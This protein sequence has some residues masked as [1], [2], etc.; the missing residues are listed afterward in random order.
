[1]QYKLFCRLFQLLLFFMF[2]AG[3]KNV[4]SALTDRSQQKVA[5][6]NVFAIKNMNV[7]PMT[8]GAEILPN[9]T[10]IIKNEKIVSLSGPIPDHAEIIDGKG[11]WLLPGLI[12]MHVHVPS[13]GHFNTTFPTRAAT[14]FTNTQDVMTPYVANGVTTIFEL[15]AKAGHF[16]QRNE[17]ARGDVIG[18]RM[19]LAALIN[20]GDG[21]GRIANTPSDGRQTVRIAKAEGYEFIKVY[22]QLNIETYKAIVDEANKQGLKV[23][24]HIPN[25]FRGKLKDAFVPHFGMVAHAEE[26]SKQTEAFSDQD[27][28]RFAQLAKE[29]GTWITPTLTIMV[30]AAS[31]ARSLDE[32]R[33]LHSLQY[34]HPLLQSKWLTSNNYN[35][36]T[37]PNRVAYFEKMINFHIRLVRA[38]KEAG[39][40]MVVGTDAGS[41][42]VVGGFSLHDE[43]ELLVEAGLTPEEA[44]TSATRLPS[45]W[46]GIDSK[47]GTVEAGK[48]ADLVLLD[49]NPLNDI[50]NTRKIS[51]VFV[52]G[53]WLDKARI[54]AMLSDLS[55]RNTASK[56][57]YDWKKR[58]EY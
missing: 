48:Y 26:F 4:S 35:K 5:Q 49:A 43:I 42:G 29:N 10:V 8:S 19:A 36:G 22:S 51:G 1:M 46:L 55:K 14:I 20:G 56:D 28:K 16:G 13:D 47:V 37:S 44:L 45:I 23:I 24:G 2:A 39:V 32:L 18:P 58:E 31:Q 52:N 33:A 50:K 3:C 15:T 7:I 54:S 6:Q 11:K 34:V 9:A 21:S 38:F 40:P 30:W 57:K 25:A 53:Q 17:I 12:D 41:S 27:A